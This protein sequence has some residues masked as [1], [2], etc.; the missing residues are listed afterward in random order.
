M[1]SRIGI[2]AILILAACLGTS[3]S[4]TNSQ[5][6][7]PTETSVI[8]VSISNIY[9]ANP[10]QEVKFAMKYIGG[11]GTLSWHV[12]SQP[13]WLVLEPTSGIL[14][15]EY[16]YMYATVNQSVLQSLAYGTYQGVAEIYSAEGT[17]LIQTTLVYSQ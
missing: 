2:R 6:I 5:P 8:Y 14:T 16:T 9:F 1:Q 15:N 7:R 11:Y 17:K 4:C 10:G 12:S 3:L 13:A